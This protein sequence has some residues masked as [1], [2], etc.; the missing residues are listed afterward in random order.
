MRRVV[1]SLKVVRSEELLNSRHDRRQLFSYRLPNNIEVHV[2]IAVN[3]TIAHGDDVGPGNLRRLRPKFTG[4][5]YWLPRQKSRSTSQGPAPTR[6]LLLIH[7]GLISDE[8]E[9]F[10]R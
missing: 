7:L 5:P 1:G 3:K 8:G 2:E 4:K 6:G 9:R 10:V